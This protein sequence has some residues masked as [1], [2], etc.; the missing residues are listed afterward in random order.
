MLVEIT[1]VVKPFFRMDDPILL[2]MQCILENM[3]ARFVT[4]QSQGIGKYNL[5]LVSVWGN[6]LISYNIIKM[7]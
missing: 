2:A 5:W 6:S 7:K 4:C 1:K 3:W